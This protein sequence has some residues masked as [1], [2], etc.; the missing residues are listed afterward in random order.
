MAQ[1]LVAAAVSLAAAFGQGATER[2]VKRTPCANSHQSGRRIVSNLDIVEFYVPRF[3]KTKRRAD[4]DY[5]EY[6][7]RY[8]PERDK[9]WLKFMFGPM[10]GGHSPHDLDNSSIQWTSRKWACNGD[11]DGTDWIGVEADGRKWRHIAIPLGFAT[12]QGVPPKAADYFDRI[13]NTMCCG[14]CPACKK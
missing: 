9:L 6:Y 5:V 1:T 4:V 14:K 7:I 12:Y 10:V 11:E 13:L 3:A 8:G 2:P